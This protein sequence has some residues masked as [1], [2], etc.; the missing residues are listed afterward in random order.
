MTKRNSQEWFSLIES[1]QSSN[2][3]QKEFC[4]Q[5]SVA[6]GAFHYWYKKARKEFNVTDPG[7]QFRVL[8]R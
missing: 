5:R 7:S 2:L 8:F 1:W 4:V 6:Y 3:T